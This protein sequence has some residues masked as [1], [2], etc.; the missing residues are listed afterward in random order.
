MGQQQVVI[1]TLQQTIDRRNKQSQQTP[2]AVAF[3]T[4][5]CAK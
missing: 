4:V 3:A 1:V 2:T 5:Q